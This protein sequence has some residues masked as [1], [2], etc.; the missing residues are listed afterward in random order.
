MIHFIQ[1]K[2][3]GLLAK[4]QLSSKKPNQYNANEYRNLWLVIRTGLCFLHEIGTTKQSNGM[5]TDVK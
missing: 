4:Q 2:M 3:V 5:L 1:I